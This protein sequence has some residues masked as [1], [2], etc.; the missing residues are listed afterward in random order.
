MMTADAVLSVWPLL[1]LLAYALLTCMSRILSLRLLY[2][3]RVHDQI[4]KSREMRR[5]YLQDLY[6]NERMT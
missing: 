2:D 5:R 3:I 1:L 6:D 4:Y